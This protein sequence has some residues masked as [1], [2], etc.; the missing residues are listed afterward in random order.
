[1]QKSLMCFTATYL[2]CN[3]MM[4]S[5]SYN[6]SES[7]TKGSA[8][9]SRRVCGNSKKTV[10]LERGPNEN[11]SQHCGVCRGV[12][13]SPR[14]TALPQTRVKQGEGQGC[15][16]QAGSGSQLLV[17]RP[18]QSC[19]PI[20]APGP[21]GGCRLPPAGR[22][23]L[24]ASSW[25]PPCAAPVPAACPAHGWH[26]WL[27]LL[28]PLCSLPPSTAPVKA[29]RKNRVIRVHPVREP[30]RSYSLPAWPCLSWIRTCCSPGMCL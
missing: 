21:P 24:R 29:H 7:L 28:R 17:P 11:L 12:E 22:A 8:W 5:S 10:V 1:M 26:R 20:P 15:E 25:L 14:G 30:R 2:C 18:P 16:E 6:A 27:R 13:T 4:T 23:A 9:I 3:H 19:F